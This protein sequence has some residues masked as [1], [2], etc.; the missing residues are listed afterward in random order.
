MAQAYQPFTPIPQVTAATTRQE[1]RDWFC[2]RRAQVLALGKTLTIKSEVGKDQMDALWRKLGALETQAGGNTPL[3]TVV[4][5]FQQWLVYPNEDAWEFYVAEQRKL[6]AA[7][8][9]RQR[10]AAQ[11]RAVSTAKQEAVDAAIALTR[12]YGQG[13]LSDRGT[14][15][16]IAGLAFV[17]NAGVTYTGISGVNMHTHAT[18]PLIDELLK[19]THQAEEWPQKS[20][21][22]VDALKT[23]LHTTVPAINS[24][25]QIPQD[26]L[27]FHARVWNPGGVQSGKTVTPHWQPR[28]ACKNCLQWVD[29]IG[30][31][32]A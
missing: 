20:C 23:Y 32:L 21:A 24:I 7:E 3:A 2:L 1:V 13:L 18:H 6:D 15:R 10:Q 8:L 19:G 12:T 9:E 16:V 5:D 29:K 31:L 26:T 17:N 27:V 30:A 14:G 11:E 22:E 4:Q 28:G 25:A